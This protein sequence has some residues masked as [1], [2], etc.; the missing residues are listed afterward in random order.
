[1]YTPPTAKNG[2]Y[3]TRNLTSTNYSRGVNYLG[4]YFDNSML[5]K[6]PYYP[7]TN[8]AGMIAYLNTNY[9]TYIESLGELADSVD[10]KKIIQAM[11]D[12]AARGLTD[13]PRPAYFADA[14]IKNTGYT[15]AAKVGDVISAVGEGLFDFTKIIWI[16]SIIGVGVFV[17]IE[18]GPQIKTLFKKAKAV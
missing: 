17:Y 6:A 5:A 18:F 13:Y 1:M 9:P 11:K 7:I 10:D 4:Y 2:V 3:F 16:A 12:A 15:L 8:K 14:I